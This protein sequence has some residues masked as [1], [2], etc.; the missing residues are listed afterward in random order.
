MPTGGLPDRFHP[1]QSQSA[2]GGLGGCL[3]SSISLADVFG[4]QQIFVVFLHLGFDSRVI[5]HAYRKVRHLDNDIEIRFQGTGRAES[6]EGP[7]MPTRHVCLHL[8]GALC[9]RRN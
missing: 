1:L 3:P 9:L 6:R 7:G 4:R 2:G 5:T 8:Q